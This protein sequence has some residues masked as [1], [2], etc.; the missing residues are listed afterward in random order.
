MNIADQVDNC[1]K[2]CLYKEEEL[3]QDPRRPPADAIIVEGIMNTFA[4]HPNR[5]ETHRGELRRILCGFP[6]EF[7]ID[8]GG[9]WSFLN[10]CMT[11]DGDQWGEHYNMEQLMCLGIAL[12]LVKYNMDR[13]FWNVMPG[14][15]PYF[16]ICIPLADRQLTV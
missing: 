5:L 1:M 6:D 3:L 15:M 4:F 11:K 12:R 13:S 8:G 2:D 16:T 9:G 14:G 7:Y 10:F